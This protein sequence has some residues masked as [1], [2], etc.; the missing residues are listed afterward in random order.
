MATYFQ[1]PIPPSSLDVFGEGQVMHRLSQLIANH[2]TVQRWCFKLNNSI[3]GQCIAYCDVLAHLP[4]YQWLL[5]ESERYGA[6]WSQ[7]WVQEVATSRITE[8]L[9]VVLEKH[10]K[11]V[12]SF[13]FPTWTVFLEEMKK[14]GGV[15]QAC[16]P[17]DSVTAITVNLLM[18][19]DGVGTILSTAD[20]V[21]PRPFWKWG[22]SV[23]QTS[24]CLSH[25]TEEVSKVASA[26]QERGVI[27]HVSVDFVT[28]ISPDTV[29]VYGK[30]VQYIH[31]CV[32]MYILH[33]HLSGV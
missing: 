2:L 19:P 21:N 26:L 11:M 7:K 29:S 16:P 32:C 12:D 1:V 3:H 5:K 25:L 20:Q 6:E 24:I 31:T 9:P 22:V 33:K 18:E 13:R 28:F 8:E 15:I 4:C 30:C 23:P 17:P 14:T 27:G 10:T